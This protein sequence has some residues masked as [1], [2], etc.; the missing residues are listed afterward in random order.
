LSH[1]GAEDALM[2]LLDRFRRSPD[3]KTHVV[4]VKGTTKLPPLLTVGSA[5]RRRPT[6]EMG[7]S[8]LRND[9]PPKR[10]MWVVYS[11]RTGIV[12]DLEPGDIYT[13][14]LVDEEGFNAIE[15]HVPGAQLRQAWYE[16]IPE[17]RRP[18]LEHAVRFGYHR[19]P[20]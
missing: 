8:H 18:P 11:G 17:G 16:D 10:G 19:T 3:A 14:M 15:L 4:E 13:V 1:L 20:K 12:K 7:G 6:R 9:Q 2:S 5:L